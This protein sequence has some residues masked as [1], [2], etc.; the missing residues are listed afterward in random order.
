MVAIEY[1]K[2]YHPSP[3]SSEPR[4]CTLPLFNSHAASAC[5]KQ[6]GAGGATKSSELGMQRERERERET[7]NRAQSLRLQSPQKKVCCMH[8]R[9]MM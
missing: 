6:G 3:S 8:H 7:D 4:E 9:L 5:C 2:W 1:D